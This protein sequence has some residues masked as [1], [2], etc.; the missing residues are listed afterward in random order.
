MTSV[1]YLVCREL[2]LQSDQFARYIRAQRDRWPDE[3]GAASCK[4]VVAAA[5]TI[6]DFAADL[7][8]D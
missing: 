3:P 1:A 4:L 8:I 2:G 7:V 5:E 6:L